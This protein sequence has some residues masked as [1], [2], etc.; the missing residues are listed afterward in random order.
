MSAVR[1]SEVVQHGDT[2]SHVFGS[3]NIIRYL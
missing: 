1:S 3:L 2:T